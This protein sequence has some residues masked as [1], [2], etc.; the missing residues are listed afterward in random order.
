MIWFKITCKPYSELPYS[1]ST[2]LST[3]HFHYNGIK[4]FL[5][6]EMC[7]ILSLIRFSLAH[8]LAY[9]SS[10]FP[11]SALMRSVARWLFFF[12]CYFFFWWMMKLMMMRITEYMSARV[13]EQQPNIE[14]KGER[15]REKKRNEKYGLVH[16]IIIT[17]HSPLWSISAHTFVEWKPIKHTYTRRN[18]CGT[19]ENQVY[20]MKCSRLSVL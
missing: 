17:P 11:S 19:C 14:R 2:S 16:V 3:A 6:V 12:L 8:P 9:S 15:E 4:L 5:S 13:F 18:T 7:A 1:A 10:L 20:I